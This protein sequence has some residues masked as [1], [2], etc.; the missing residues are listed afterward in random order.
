[1]V[2]RA[3]DRPLESGAALRDEDPADVLRPRLL[4]RLGAPAQVVTRIAR[5]RI[6]TDEED[7]RGLLDAGVQP[8]RDGPPRAGDDRRTDAASFGCGHHEVGRT[9][10]RA[11]VR[12]EHLDVAREV[13]GSDVGDQIVDVLG[14]VP[15]RDDHRDGPDRRQAVP[16]TWSEWSF[17]ST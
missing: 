1:A 3:G 9:V 8:R 13:L 4:R 10:A 16:D 6:E 17:A 14:L 11:S 7:T 5:V 12:D 2:E 15:H